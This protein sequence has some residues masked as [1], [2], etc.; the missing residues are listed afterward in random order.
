MVDVITCENSPVM[1]SAGICTV[2]ESEVLEVIL[3]HKGDCKKVDR[4]PSPFG[5]YM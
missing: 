4:N 5:M 3:N 2:T 1:E